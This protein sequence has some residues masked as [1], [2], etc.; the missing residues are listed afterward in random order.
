MTMTEARPTAAD[1]SQSPA[2]PGPSPVGQA[3]VDSADHKILGLVLIGVSLVLFLV[4]RAVGSAL[5]AEVLTAG[6]QVL[7]GNSRRFTSLY[8]TGIILLWVGPVWMGLATYVLPLQIGSSRL[9][10]PRVQALAVWTHVGGAG[11]FVLGHLI[12]P[13]PGLGLTDRQ[14]LQAPLGG[15]NTGTNLIL[16]SFLLLGLA[17]LL[18]AGNLLTTALSMRADGMSLGRMPLFSWGVVAA[19]AGSLF[20]TPVFLASSLLLYID[21]HFAGSS[22]FADSRAAALVWQKGLW[23]YGRPEALLLLVPALGAACD[24]VVTAARRPLAAP[25]P[26]PIPRGLK[27]KLPALPG[28]TTPVVGHVVGAGA[29]F[30]ATVFALLS[31]VQDRRALKAVI[32]PTASVATTLVAAAAGL[33]VLLWLNTLRQGKVKP[34]V[35]LGFVGA[36]VLVGGAAA[37]N[38]VVAAIA[39][40]HGTELGQGMIELITI[41]VPTLLAFGALHHWAKKLFGVPLSVPAGGLALLAGLGGTVAVGIGQSIAGYAGTAAHTM[42]TEGD[43]RAGFV[44]AQVGHVLL[45][46]AGILVTLDVARA[47]AARRA[48]PARPADVADGVTLE[49]AAPSPPPA[50]NFPE[51]PDIRSA[52]PLA[53]LAA[54]KPKP[55][56]APRRGKNR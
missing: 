32:L 17:T 55:A 13:P 46:L 35:A 14:P 1:P 15:V 54:T 2:A 22:L 48:G 31:W 45:L 24:I 44:L 8:E 5:G 9:A 33:L 11:L 34:T 6:A 19:A 40:V 41:G 3:V 30:A 18:S 39:G 12:D 36:A 4:L 51:L 26:P 25:P 21:L 56:K 10:F 37:L 29:L 38:A 16:A 23:L 27:A 52:A 20:A 43:A 47:L 49:W 50:D 42:N 7:G 53:D 28:L